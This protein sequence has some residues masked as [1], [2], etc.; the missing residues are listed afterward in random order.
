MTRKAKDLSPDQ[1]AAIESLLGRQVQEDEEISV[2]ATQALSE[3]RRRELADQLRIYFAEVDARREPGSEED[4]EDIL[5]EAMRSS[6]TNY[7]PHR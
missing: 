2:R 4:V 1:R 5:A 3:Q 6:R 7:R